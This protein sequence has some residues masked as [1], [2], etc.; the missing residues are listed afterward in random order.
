MKKHHPK[1]EIL[2]QYYDKYKSYDKATLKMLEE[3][4]IE[5]IR[6]VKGLTLEE[7]GYILGI[8]RE[9]VR[10]LESNAIKKLK[11]IVLKEKRDLKEFA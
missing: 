5:D 4:K 8:T 2:K 11:Q 10:Q 1:I 3:G 6:E 9:R 7:T